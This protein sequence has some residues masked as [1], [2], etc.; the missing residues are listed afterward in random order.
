MCERLGLGSRL[1]TASMRLTL[2][3][4]LALIFS[5]TASLGV[6]IVLGAVEGSKLSVTGRSFVL[7][8]VILGFSVRRYTSV[9]RFRSHA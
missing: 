3:L 7:M 4:L 9:A 5:I 6:T 8:Q 1:V 2:E